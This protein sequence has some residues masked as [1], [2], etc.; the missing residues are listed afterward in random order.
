MQERWEGVDQAMMQGKTPPI[1][2]YQV[3]EIY[4][5]VD[6]NH[7]VSVSRQHGFDTIEAYVTEFQTPFKPSADADLDE[8]LI[9]AEQVA[10]RE[11]AGEAN[12]EAASAMVFTCSGCYE[13][14]SEQVETYRQQ[15]QILQDKP[16]YTFEQAFSDWREEVYDPAIEAIQDNDL[17]S[18]FPERTE[19]D[20]FIWSWQ[21]NKE[22]EALEV[23]D[24]VAE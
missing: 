2:V 15:K 5:V 19:A 24:E 8:I 4:F 20:L 16:S 12:A 23:D 1:E 17:V 14:V 6:G 22:I 9:K 11:K 10:F 18:Q 21:N 7:R 3:G 13:D